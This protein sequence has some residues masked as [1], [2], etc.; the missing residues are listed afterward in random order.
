VSSLPA[1]RTRTP[2]PSSTMRVRGGVA[3]NRRAASFVCQPSYYPFSCPHL[4]FVGNR[5]PYG[6]NANGRQEQ[7]LW[8]STVV[9]A[10]NSL[11]SQSGNHVPALC[12][13]A[14]MRSDG[15]VRF[16][17]TD[18]SAETAL[19][20]A[21]GPNQTTPKSSSHV[22]DMT[23]TPTTSS[24]QHDYEYPVV[25]PSQRGGWGV[26]AR[27]DLSSLPPTIQQVSLPRRKQQ[28]SKKSRSKR[29]VSSSST[30]A[31]C[32]YC[33]EL[34]FVSENRSGVCPDAPDDCTACIEHAT[35]LCAARAVL[36]HCVTDDDGNYGSVCGAGQ[37]SP[38][39]SGSLSDRRRRRKWLL[40]A[41]LSVILPCLWCYPSLSACHRCALRR[42]HCGARHRAA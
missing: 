18:V 27:G 10:E 38:R 32:I 29:S 16:S 17:R 13:E 25:L 3:G 24:S 31:R 1:S 7:L 28:K 39:A 41:L 2:S 6:R 36:Y 11:C 30:R 14:P 40:L 9:E 34:F 33:Q 4:D 37:S 5:L 23:I 22:V 35:C 19:S 21:S 12:D 26:M 8:Q 20:D 42:G 15:Y